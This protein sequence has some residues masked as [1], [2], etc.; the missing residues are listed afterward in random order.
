VS[1][2]D[3]ATLLDSPT[4]MTMARR[5]EVT[6][7]NAVVRI[8][9]DAGGELSQ[10]FR[11]RYQVGVVPQIVQLGRS[12][13]IDRG[14]AVETLRAYSG[15]LLRAEVSGKSLTPT[16]N[17][18]RDD[19]A[20]KVQHDWTHAILIAPSSMHSNS[21]VNAVQGSQQVRKSSVIPHQFQ[22]AVIDSGTISAG[23][24]VLAFDAVARTH[25]GLFGD[26]LVHH[27][28]GM[29]RLVHTY[30][31]VHDT[32]Y[33]DR[34]AAQLTAKEWTFWSRLC[35]RFGNT[36]VFYVNS[37]KSEVARRVRG[38]AA[39]LDYA[40]SRA[41]EGLRAGLKTPGICISY[42]G[43]PGELEKTAPFNALVTLAKEK[44]IR[45]LV[46]PMSLV[47]AVRLGPRA[48]VVGFASS[49]FR[50]FPS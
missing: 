30:V 1:R 44:R 16:I 32:H 33:L 4:R 6:R 18:F 26:R 25:V 24:G 15:K 47:E 10:D 9:L 8:I 50:P 29:R 31:V 40:F 27:L 2:E 22:M 12:E 14:D 28:E 3:V 38:Y 41:I 36:P 19:V 17:D 48:M 39:G 37:G 43:D 5:V 7:E 23:A 20:S 13:I 35:A 49:N 34:D 11:D 46:S 21:F 45:V 42:A